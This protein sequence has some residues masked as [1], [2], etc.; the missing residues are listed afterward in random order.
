MLV[1]AQLGLQSIVVMSLH[2]NDRVAK[3]TLAG[4]QCLGAAIDAAVERVAMRGRPSI[5]IICGDI[6]MARA[7]RGEDGLWLD[8]TLNAL[9]SR[10][11]IPVADWSGDC[12]FIGLRE[13]LVQQL[14]ITGN[15]WGQKQSTTAAPAA[16]T[17]SPVNT[18]DC[19]EFLERVGAG[20]GSHEVHWPYEL[21]LRIRPPR[22]V[23]SCPGEKESR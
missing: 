22:A 13:T 6:N 5:D 12:C 9:E 2:L 3:K 21:H 19:P 10:R 11:L 4:P 14:H 20:P 8:S 18:W 17:D 1:E 7:G 15:C 16:G 23:Q